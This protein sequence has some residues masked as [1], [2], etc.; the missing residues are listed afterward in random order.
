MKNK[1][2]SGIWALGFRPWPALIGAGLVLGLSTGTGGRSLLPEGPSDHPDGP[3]VA[4]DSPA[5]KKLLIVETGWSGP[6]KRKRPRTL[7][8]TGRPLG[9]L[10]DPTVLDPGGVSR[11][12]YDK[13][14]FA[15]LNQH[16]YSLLNQQQIM[17][18]V[19]KLVMD[20]TLHSDGHISGM[21]ISQGQEDGLF[22]LLC[23]QT[24]LGIVPFSPWPACMSR[25]FPTNQNSVTI[26][27]YHHGEFAG[28]SRSTMRRERSHLKYVLSYPCPSIR[29]IAPKSSVEAK[30]SYLS[31]PSFLDWPRGYGAD[32]F[33]APD[34][35]EKIKWGK[36][37]QMTPGKWPSGAFPQ[38][39]DV[40]HPPPMR[41]SGGFKG[42]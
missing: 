8:K 19:G 5:G 15:A 10:P 35:D 1:W 22:G 41:P 29:P 13:T 4:V 7:A 36:P 28:N 21:N 6:P 39:K 14:L 11:D 3:E 27:F 20:F 42:R 38:G 26:T 23:Q 33:H 34:W 9:K 25:T 30:D 16:Y 31:R 37:E 32:P 18:R 2:K 17:P 12:L 24:V 40:F